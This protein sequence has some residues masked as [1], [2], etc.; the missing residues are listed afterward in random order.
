MRKM[1]KKEE[2]EYESPLVSVIMPVYNSPDLFASIDSILKQK[3]HRMELLII[4][5][6]SVSFDVNEVE[7][8]I[9]N[10]NSGNIVDIYVDRHKENLGTVKTMNELFKMSRGEYIFTLACDD[11][12]YD[13]DVI[14]EWVTEFERTG[15]DF[16]T[17]KRECF[18]Y[19]FNDSLGIKPERKQIRW[20]RILPPSILYKKMIPCN[21]I[22]GC[23]TARSKKSIDFIGY[24]DERYRIIEDYPFYLK[25][26]RQGYRIFFWNRLTVKSRAGGVSESNRK[27]PF[28]VLEENKIFINEV[29]PYEK[30]T[31]RVLKKYYMYSRERNSKSKYETLREKWEGNQLMLDIVF[32]RFNIVKCLTNPRYVI[33]QLKKRKERHIV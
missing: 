2:L 27:N 15:A 6:C 29:M 18:D 28:Y 3:Y 1:K 16:I 25:I 33:C 12:Y 21:F 7:N 26:L 20:I 13:E 30:H 23:C 24:Y 32:I 17:S 11:L 9:M 22:F 14:G 31:R 8:Y 10:N 19:E 5:D 4:D